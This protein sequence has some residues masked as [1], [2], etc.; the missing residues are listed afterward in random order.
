ML[1][2]D[3]QI[4][5]Q[6][7]SSEE[8]SMPVIVG[9]LLGKVLYLVRARPGPAL[10][11][12]QLFGLGAKFA[13]EFALRFIHVPVGIWLLHSESLERLMSA[14]LSDFPSLLDRAF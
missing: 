6:E 10:A 2:R 13:P 1:W 4:V 5:L 9:E 14:T 12:A 8:Q 11:I 7:K 3:E